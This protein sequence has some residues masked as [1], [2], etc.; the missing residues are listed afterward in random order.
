MIIFRIILMSF[1]SIFLLWSVNAVGQNSATII[2][3][4]VSTESTARIENK[5]YTFI[6][7]RYSID[8]SAEV[9]NTPEK[10]QI[11]FDNSFRTKGGPD[12]K[13]YLSKKSM[14]E[15]ENETVNTHSVK[16]GVLKSK[17]G[18]QSYILP[19]DIS[20]SDYKSVIIHCETFSIL[21]GGFDL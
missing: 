13:V 2:D 14:T 17:K 20:L 4:H 11:V 8:G 3:S 16:I 6:K 12:L 7:K 1:F 15:L 5:N 10:T 19:D 9:I 21:W 18:E